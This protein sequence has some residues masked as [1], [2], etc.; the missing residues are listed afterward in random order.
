MHYV[1]FSLTFYLT[2][3]LVYDF[4]TGLIGISIAILVEFY[5]WI[6]VTRTSVQKHIGVARRSQV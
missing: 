1:L 6:D 2:L 5:E 3:P 4:V